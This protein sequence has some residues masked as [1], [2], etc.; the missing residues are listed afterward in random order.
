MFSVFWCLYTFISLIKLCCYH[1]KKGSENC[2]RFFFVTYIGNHNIII[3]LNNHKKWQF[4]KKSK[5]RK[6][7]NQIIYNYFFFYNF[8]KV[9]IHFTV[10][11]IVIINDTFINN[12]VIIELLLEV[13]GHSAL[14]C[15]HLFLWSNHTKT[16][17][18]NLK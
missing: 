13:Y 1:Y 18:V 3:Q 16:N 17:D 6:K 14:F 15:A 4:T 9:Y 5:T 7:T 2:F 12:N 10:D 8:L 11:N